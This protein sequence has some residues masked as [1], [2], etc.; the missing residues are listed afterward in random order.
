VL[1]Y[2]AKPFTL[3]LRPGVGSPGRV[4]M[5]LQ[6][7]FTNLLEFPHFDKNYVKKGGDAQFVIEKII[8]ASAGNCLGRE[9]G[10]PFDAERIADALVANERL[11]TRRN[12]PPAVVL[13]ADTGL[14][15]A[16]AS[17]FPLW[18]NPDEMKR[19]A[20]DGYD[21]DGCQ[22]LEDFHGANMNGDLG[23]PEAL[24]MGEY[25]D[26]DHGTQVASM[27]IGPW[28]GERLLGLI[29]ERLNIA[30]ANIVDAQ[31]GGKR[32]DGEPIIN[33]SVPTSG[34]EH[35]LG[36]AEC[37]SRK[38]LAPLLI[39]N[40]SWA[41]R[42]PYPM[43]AQYLNGAAFLTVIAA[44]NDQEQVDLEGKEQYPAD[45][46]RTSKDNILT[47]AAHDGDGN[48]AKFSNHG[49]K[50][51]DMAA[52]GCTLKTLTFG[53]KPITNS[54]TSLAAPL[55]S[56][57][58]ALLYAEGVTDL[59]EIRNRILT[60]TDFRPSLKKYVDSSGCLNIEKAVRIFQDI[61]VPLKD[62]RPGDPKFG[63]LSVKGSMLICG[64]RFSLRP[65]ILK[66]IP[67]YQGGDEPMLVIRRIESGVEFWNCPAPSNIEIEFTEE[68]GRAPQTFKL[69]DLHEIIPALK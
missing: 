9:S 65:K 15:E 20:R 61:V 53:G 36:Y 34:V 35:A 26:A 31:P 23:F 32:E 63:E 1:E 55:V 40:I 41:S 68:G 27:L 69:T 16:D 22:Y 30:I 60:T 38:K 7:S 44:G 13:I 47:V 52:P 42:S 67:H 17:N 62:G 25:I 10:W 46:R 8:S 49:R 37:L 48:I 64:G 39:L 58:A 29:R 57:T 66:I 43:L 6:R 4:A 11:T 28:V 14:R 33:I 56:L 5:A 45:Y 3:I 12:R 18:C 24:G 51:I 19:Y 59:K 2:Q 54:G 50:V 21:D